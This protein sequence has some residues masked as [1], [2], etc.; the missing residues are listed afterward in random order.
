MRILKQEDLLR[1]LSPE[2]RLKQAF[3]LSDFVRKLAILNI[4]K[5]YGNKLSKKDLFDK[6][7][8]RLHPEEIKRKEY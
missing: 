1:R 6:L 7:K 2:E 5:E 8:E 4:K 3:L